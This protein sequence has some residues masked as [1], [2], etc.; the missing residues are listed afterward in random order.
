MVVTPSF[1]LDVKL[2]H[3]LIDAYAKSG[4]SR[5]STGGMDDTLETI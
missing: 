3:A 1:K 4:T 2:S 5:T